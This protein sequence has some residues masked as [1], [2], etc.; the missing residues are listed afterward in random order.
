MV[1]NPAPCLP[2]RTGRA[3]ESRA[4]WKELPTEEEMIQVNLLLDE[5]AG[6][7]AQGLTGTVVALSFSKRLVQTIQDRVHPSF[8]YWGRQDPT[9]GQNQKGDAGKD[10]AAPVNLKEPDAADLEASSDS[11]VGGES[12]VEVVGATAPPNPS[13]PGQWKRRR[14][15]RKISAAKASMRGVLP[16]GGPAATSRSGSEEPGAED[17]PELSG[18][19]AGTGAR[20]AEGE[21]ALG[22]TRM[23]GVG[24]P[25]LVLR[26]QPPAA[27][28][29]MS[30]IARRSGGKRKVEESADETRRVE[31]A[32]SPPL[33]G[34][35]PRTRIHRE[36]AQSED[37]VAEEAGRSA[38][39]KA[40]PLEGVETPPA[41]PSSPQLENSSRELFPAGRD[42]VL[43]EA[44][45]TEQQEARREMSA[46]LAE[47][48]LAAARRAKESAEALAGLSQRAVERIR[49]VP[50]ADGRLEQLES[51]LAELEAQNR[52]LEKQQAGTEKALVDEKQGKERVTLYADSFVFKLIGT[53]SGLEKEVCAL[54]RDQT[55]CEKANTDLQKGREAV[56]ARV[57]VIEGAE[58]QLA[59]ALAALGLLT[60]KVNA[61]LAAF[62]PEGTAAAE[63][64]E[65]RLEAAR[66]RLEVFAR[67]VANDVSQ[68]ILGLVKSHYP[69][70]DLEPVGDG[71]APDTSDLAWSNYL[72]DARPIAECMAADLNL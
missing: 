50:A 26:P 14:A 60:G 55:S 56:E 67:R 66:G 2:A 52:L 23:G 25:L 62:E 43:P 38:S 49:G 58:A 12:D 8:E 15:V 18:E 71:M 29:K 21:A 24:S 42:P 39:E 64:L 13:A 28:L 41:S 9:R 70:A 40:A 1:S 6:L 65:A 45:H 7:S 5:I 47:E 31:A 44:S 63:E 54:K 20:C 4:C 72:A 46:E 10:A 22:L 59:E 17:A 30:F 61:V 57:D 34:S 33:V 16:K 11:S 3:P 68:Y 19:G 36:A 35:P 27:P 53:L 69:E 51:Q 32:L 48:L 37:E